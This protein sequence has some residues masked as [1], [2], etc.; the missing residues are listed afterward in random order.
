MIKKNIYL[1]VF[2]I[3]WTSKK[4]NISF[5]I[6]FLERFLKISLIRYILLKIFFLL[7]LY[8]ING[9]YCVQINILGIIFLLNIKKKMQWSHNDTSFRDNFPQACLWIFIDESYLSNFWVPVGTYI[10]KMQVKLFEHI[11]MMLLER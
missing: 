10:C 9:I 2:V 11:H 7:Y 3:L 6:P 4:I 1:Y 5:K 8:D